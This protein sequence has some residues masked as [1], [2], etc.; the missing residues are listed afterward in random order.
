L[1]GAPS[2][3]SATEIAA[4]T[5]R[6]R[7]NPQPQAFWLFGAGHVGRAVAYAIAPL[8]FAL[9]WIDGREKQFPEPAPAGVRC[10]ALAMPELVVDEAP[11]NTVF[12]VMTHSHPLD[13]AIAKR[14][15]AA[16]ISPISA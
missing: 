3:G 12:A 7:V 4:V 8:G 10:L 2:T 14:C 11:Q 9:T 6:E 5:I 13:E 1:G 15:C 16:A